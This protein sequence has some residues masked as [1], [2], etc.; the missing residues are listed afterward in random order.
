MLP[1]ANGNPPAPNKRSPD[2]MD[3]TLHPIAIVCYLSAQTPDLDAD[4]R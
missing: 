3:C 4:K 2:H 1:K